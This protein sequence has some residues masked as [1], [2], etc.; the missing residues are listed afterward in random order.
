MA[1]FIDLVDVLWFVPTIW[2]PMIICDGLA[3][4]DGRGVVAEDMRRVLRHP[5]PAGP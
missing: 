2:A 5:A 1:V 3:R 4:V